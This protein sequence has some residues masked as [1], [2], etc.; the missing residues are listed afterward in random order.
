M[1][2]V[3]KKWCFWIEFDYE[4]VVGVG[5]WKVGNKIPWRWLSYD[6]LYYDGQWWF[7]RIGPLFISR[8]PY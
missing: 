2:F 6:K 5:W 8:G 4:Y 1:K 7:L 3:I